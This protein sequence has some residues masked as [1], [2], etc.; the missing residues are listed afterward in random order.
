MK[1]S[2]QLSFAIIVFNQQGSFNYR[3][4]IFCDLWTGYARIFPEPNACARTIKSQRF[5]VVLFTPK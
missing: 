1:N 5:L 3:V 2:S 4:G